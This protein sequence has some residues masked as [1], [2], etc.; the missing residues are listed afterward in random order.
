M[1]EV[2][3]EFATLRMFWYSC[4]AKVE[5]IDAKAAPMMVPA[6]PSLLERR[7]TVPAARPPARIWIHEIPAKK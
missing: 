5:I 7:N 3:F 6:R 4:D 2:S 1:E